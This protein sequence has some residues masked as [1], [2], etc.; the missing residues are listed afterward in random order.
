MFRAL[1]F[2]SPWTICIV[3]LCCASAAFADESL[4]AV[5]DEGRPLIPAC[6]DPS[7]FHDAWIKVVERVCLKCHTAD[8]DASDSEFV[9]R[10]I[11]RVP[12]AE[13]AAAIRQNCAALAAMAASRDANGQPRL[14]AKATGGLEHGGGEALKPGSTELQVLADF[15]RTREQKPARS[16]SVKTQFDDDARSLFDGVQMISDQ[17]L[18]RRCALSLVARLPRDDERSAVDERGLEA[19]APILDAMLHEDAFYERLLEGFND[20]LLTRGIDGNAETV[21]SYDH[22]EHT[23]LWY[24]EFSLDH[25]PESQR[26]R[27]RYKLADQYREAMLREPL[28]LIRYIVKNDRPFTEI[29]TANYTMMSPYTARGYGL[30]E[31]L[32]D[33][34]RDPDDPF[35]FV[36]ARVK[37]LTHRDGKVQPTADG[38]YPHAGLLTMFQYLRRYPTTE[39]NRNRLR[40]RMYYQHF[41]GVDIMNLAPRVSDAAAIDAKYEIPT[42]QAAECVVCHKTIDPVAGLFQDYYSDEGYYRPRKEGWFVDMFGPGREGIDL[43]EPEQWRTLQ[44]LAEQTASDPRFAIAMV[45]HVYYILMGRKV[46]LRP[47]DIDDPHF[48]ARRRA[49]LAQREL[50]DR[51]ADRLRREGFN[52]KSVFKELTV[53]PFY[54]AHGLATA[55]EEPER[56]AELDDVGLVRLLGPEQIERK[57]A[58]IFGKPWGR[59]TDSYAILYGGID[60]KEVT[61]RLTEPSGAIGAIQRMLAN[62]VAC[63]NVAA[64]FALPAGERRLF[65]GVELDVIPGAGDEAERRIRAAIAHLHRLVLGRDDRPDDAE[66]DLT[67]ELFAGVIDEAKSLGR[68]EPIESYFCKSAGQEGPRDADPHYTL[69]AWR[70]VVTYLLR[71]PEFLYE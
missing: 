11:S 1:T 21:L 5:A 54:R 7:S 46:L 15:V 49:Y 13:R 25:V 68:F 17:Q 63:K 56:R 45:E 36:P 39:T 18:L 22:F 48:A 10:D 8:G 52:L 2:R 67:Y 66:V 31:E 50:I 65:P 33:Q 37:A 6:L 19:V 44:W 35:E 43:P 70:A 55:A 59:L 58:A 14:L 57:I 34:F 60:S 51:A 53:S 12:P 47:D 4:D 23:R 61:E 9:L 30:Y 64:D 3:A 41:L 26:Q 62:A 42:M 32:K 27:A 16:E 69:R 24:Q 40:A 29:L 38:F 71:Q 20:I 28:E